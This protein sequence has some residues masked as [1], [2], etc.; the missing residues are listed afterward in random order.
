MQQLSIFNYNFGSPCRLGENGVVKSNPAA[1]E[2]L[3]SVLHRFPTPDQLVNRFGA[4]SGGSR[5]QKATHV[6]QA[7]G[8]ASMKPIS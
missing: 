1:L 2:V 5:E 8:F 3:K 7:K 6:Q 4:E